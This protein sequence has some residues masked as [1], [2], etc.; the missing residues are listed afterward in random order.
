MSPLFPKPKHEDRD[1]PWRNCNRR[2]KN[3][4]RC[5]RLFHISRVSST[6]CFQCW[7]ELRLERRVARGDR[8]RREAPYRPPPKK[9]WSQ[10]HRKKQIEEAGARCKVCGITES[11][12]KVAYGKGFIRDH[13]IP[14]RYII[15]HKLDDPHLDI[16][17]EPL[18]A[19]CDAR[20]RSAE[21]KLF[22][23]DMLGFLLDLKRWGWDMEEVREL[24]IF[25]RIYSQAMEHHFVEER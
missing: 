12:C 25:Y 15:Q 13:T 2:L 1:S 8:R 6:K 22:K 23:G 4:S 17:I 21:A 14:V 24:F 10:E 19:G 5:N 18:C 7:K 11:A 9:F 20:K 16:N 3:G